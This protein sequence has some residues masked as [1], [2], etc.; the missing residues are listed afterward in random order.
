MCVHVA[1]LKLDLEEQLLSYG[2]RIHSRAANVF[3][4]LTAQKRCASRTKTQPIYVTP[5]SIIA[6]E[7]PT[8][9]MVRR[10]PVMTAPVIVVPA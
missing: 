7:S 1:R 8:F 9:A 10:G 3:A 4:V 6:C 5:V 2:S